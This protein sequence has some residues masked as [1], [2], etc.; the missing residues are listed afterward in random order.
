LPATAALQVN[1]QAKTNLGFQKANA[2]KVT[3]PP[4]DKKG[5]QVKPWNSAPN[6]MK[7]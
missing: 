3:G 6:L 4:A 5:I 2:K 1:H 7:S